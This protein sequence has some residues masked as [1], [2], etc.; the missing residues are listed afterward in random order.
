MLSRCIEEPVKSQTSICDVCGNE[1]DNDIKDKI[2]NDEI[3]KLYF[4]DNEVTTDHHC[5]YGNGDLSA[6]TFDE[7]VE[8]YN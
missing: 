3:Y 1:F 8:E 5:L 6:L 4:Q 7:I 2:A